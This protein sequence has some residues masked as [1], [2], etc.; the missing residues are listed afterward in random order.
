[1]PRQSHTPPI[2]ADFWSRLGP[3]AEKIHHDLELNLIAIDR[4]KA[5]RRARALR[6]LY[7]RARGAYG[8]P[9]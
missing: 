7:L 1:M 9:H 5:L 6:R 2:P 8:P 4:A 3:L